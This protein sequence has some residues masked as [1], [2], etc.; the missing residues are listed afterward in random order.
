MTPLLLALALQATPLAPTAVPTEAAPTIADTLS[1]LEE[2]YRSTC[3]E[4]GILYHAYDDLCDA[5]RKQ[6]RDYR[7]KVEQEERRAAAHRA[8]PSP[9]PKP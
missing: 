5:L 4:T 2:T 1:G 7:N 3:G 9:A 6:I 8:P